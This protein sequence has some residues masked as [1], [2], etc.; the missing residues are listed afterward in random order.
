[1]MLS[2][3]SGSEAES[4]AVIERPEQR[5]GRGGRRRKDEAETRASQLGRA[6]STWVMFVEDTVQRST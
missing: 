3:R 5:K 6:P 1:M 4:I 2:F